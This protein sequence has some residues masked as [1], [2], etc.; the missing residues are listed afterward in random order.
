VKHKTFFYY[1]RKMSKRGI[2]MILEAAKQQQKKHKLSL[3]QNK[4]IID[5]GQ[6]SLSL[7][8]AKQIVQS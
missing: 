4:Q 2:S 7:E 6:N 5:Q 8:V 1:E 3:Q